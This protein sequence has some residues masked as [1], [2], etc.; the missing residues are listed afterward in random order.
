MCFVGRHLARS[1]A[2]NARDGGLRH[3]AARLFRIPQQA[4]GARQEDVVADGLVQAVLRAEGC[5]DVLLRRRQC[6]E[7]FRCRLP[8]RLQGA[9]QRADFRWQETRVRATV[10]RPHTE[11]LHLRY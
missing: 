9:Q 11:E 5:C 3:S 4:A 7:G 2:E 8:S 1:V 6:R 10:T